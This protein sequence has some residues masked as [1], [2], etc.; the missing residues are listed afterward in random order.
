LNSSNGMSSNCCLSA[1]SLSSSALSY[2]P[3]PPLSPYRAGRFMAMS[4]RTRLLDQ[5]HGAP[6]HRQAMAPQTAHM[7]TWV[8]C[9][10]RGTAGACAWL[11][12]T[13][14]IGTREELA[15]CALQMNERHLVIG[16]NA[17]GQRRGGSA[18]RVRT[19]P[20]ARRSRRR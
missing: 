14:S 11:W 8:P 4:H 13:S 2:R 15:L 6:Y 5:L 1:Y 18:I 7:G 17:L 10:S 20:C 3:K 9:P 12:R 16:R 19:F